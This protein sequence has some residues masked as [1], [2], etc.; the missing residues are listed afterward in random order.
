M[1]VGVLMEACSLPVACWRGNMVDVI[2]AYRLL[3]W[4]LSSGYNGAS[5]RRQRLT[6]AQQ[7]SNSLVIPIIK[8]RSSP[9]KEES[10]RKDL[11]YKPGKNIP[12]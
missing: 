4:R 8:I 7:S 11:H 10:L 3:K 1:G 5:M 2:F 12:A 6:V 9:A